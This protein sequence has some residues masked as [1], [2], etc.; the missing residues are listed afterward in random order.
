MNK[1]QMNSDFTHDKLHIQQIHNETLIYK[2]VKIYSKIFLIYL[3]K[4]DK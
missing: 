3:K 2:Y 1:I 4:G